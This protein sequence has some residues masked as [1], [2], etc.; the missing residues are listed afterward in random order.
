LS[1]GSILHNKFLT[2]LG[3]ELYDSIF[4]YSFDKYYDYK[5]RIKYSVESLKEI[6]KYDV[7]WLY[8]TSKEITI[9]NKETSLKIC[10]NDSFIPNKLVELYINHKEK[11]EENQYIKRDCNI[12]EIFKNKL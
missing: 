1:L 10:E 6:I 5:T 3:F 8:E 4:D 12:K 9:R 11:F 2:D 7:N